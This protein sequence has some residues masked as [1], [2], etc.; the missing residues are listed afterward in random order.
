[1][2]KIIFN[3]RIFAYFS[4]RI[5]HMSIRDFLA[6][7]VLSSASALDGYGQISEFPFQVSLVPVTIPN[8]PGLHS[9]TIAQHNGKWLIIGGRKDGIHARQPFNS[10]PASQSNTDIFVIDVANGQFWTASLNVLPTGLREQLQSTNMNFYQDGDT[11]Y[12]IGGY[13]YSAS[14]NNHIT[15]PYLT[16]VQVSSLI[17][18]IVNNQ[19]IV[20]Y[21]KQIQDTIFQ[22][23]GGHLKKI[24]DLFFLVGGHTFTGRYNPMGNPTFTQ[25]YTN[26]IRKFKINNSA[27]QVSYSDLSITTDPVHLRRRDYN[28]LPQIL[29]NGEQGLLISAGV[30]QPNADLPFLHP[31]EITYSSYQPITGFSQY[32]SHYHSPVVCMYDSV[33][34][35]MHSLFFGGISQY[36]YQNSLLIKDDQ[37]PFVSTISRLQ[38]DSA[39]NLT[40]YVMPVQ[41][42]GLKGAGAEFILNLSIPHFSNKVIKLNEISQ[43]AFLAGYI[44]GGISSPTLNPFS[45]NQTNTTSADATIY[46]VWITNSTTWNS[47]YKL[48]GKNPYDIKVF[49]N[50]ATGDFSFLFDIEKPTK[51]SYILTDGSGKLLKRSVNQ[52]FQP[53]QHSIRISQDYSI[54]TG[55]VHLTVIFDDLYYATQKITINR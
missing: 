31:V 32:L 28:L 46:E 37:V 18:S 24:N 49:P 7:V 43:G 51:I 12:I 40:E 55:V 20:P 45:A 52:L 15:Y 27:N 8:L 39:G 44:Y 36:Y 10:F 30:F 33:K 13:G 4:A 5:F 47:E 21:F 9:Y 26:Q 48:D 14:A 6:C 50:P 35:M 22:V 41:M 34:K 38:K 17:Q 11:L 23:T 42:P 54:S 19:S 1:M 53:G 16:T 29:P 2:N 25:Q 3:Q